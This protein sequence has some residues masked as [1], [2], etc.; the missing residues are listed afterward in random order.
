MGGPAGAGAAQLAVAAL[1]VVPIYLYELRRAGI[2]T[3][4]LAGRLATPAL[5]SIV[6]AG[7][8]VLASLFISIDVVAL[9]VAGLAAM[10]AMALLLYRMRGV[11]RSLRSV[12]EPEPTPDP[13]AMS[14]AVA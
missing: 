4:A 1:I 7:C 9:A 14:P 11:L 10:A 2:G 8:G 3:G 5:V 6:V 13:V 12:G